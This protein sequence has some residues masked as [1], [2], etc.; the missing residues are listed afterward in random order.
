MCIVGLNLKIRS[1]KRT[2]CPSLC[3]TERSKKKVAVVEECLSFLYAFYIGQNDPRLYPL[4]LDNILYRN[5]TLRV[6]Y[7]S[8]YRKSSMISFREDNKLIQKI[9][10][11]YKTNK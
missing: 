5:L 10:D 9:K 1:Q 8:S 7:Q 6:Q 4:D 2:V 3:L 11:K